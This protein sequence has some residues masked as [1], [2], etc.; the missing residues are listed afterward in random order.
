MRE[1]FPDFFGETKKETREVKRPATVVAA[2]T[3]TAAKKTQVTLT[4]S[5]EAIAR[6]LGLTNKQYATEVL[7]LNS[8]S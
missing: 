8:E 1:V 5:Q 3:R 2:P 7:K 6:R 4:K